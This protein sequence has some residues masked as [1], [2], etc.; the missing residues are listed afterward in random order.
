MMCKLNLLFLRGILELRVLSL[1]K[2]LACW[3]VAAS[4]VDKGLV[5]GQ[6]FEFNKMNVP[7]LRRVFGKIKV[8][9]LTWDRAH[10]DSIRATL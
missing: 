5:S 8:V 7:I 10:K 9:K 1:I 2:V 3:V 4:R 6:K